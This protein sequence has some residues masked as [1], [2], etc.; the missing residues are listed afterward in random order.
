MIISSIVAGVIAGRMLIFLAHIAPRFAAGNFI[1][2]FEPPCF[3][4]RS[5]T[6]R[7]SHFIGILLHLFL[8][9]IFGGVYGWLVQ[10]GIFSG[11]T[12]VSILVWTGSVSLFMG[13]VILPLEGQGIFGIKE[14]P[15]FPVDLIVTN[16][17]W[18]LLLWWFMKMWV[19]VSF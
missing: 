5:L 2:E 7:E 18:T 17:A 8:S 14:D 12:F 16:F 11:L 19:A 4:G 15:W 1:K 6:R 9:A 3:L 10:S 13:G